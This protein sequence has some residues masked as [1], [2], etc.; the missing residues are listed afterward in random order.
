MA[1]INFFLTKKIH[2]FAPQMI[3]M[4]LF[5]SSLVHFFNS[6]HNF[7]N[8]LWWNHIYCLHLILCGSLHRCLL[9][10]LDM[11]DAELLIIQWQKKKKKKTLN[12]SE[13]WHLHS[14]TRNKGGHSRLPAGTHGRRRERNS[15]CLLRQSRTTVHVDQEWK[16]VMLQQWQTEKEV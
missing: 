6:T 16:S 4:W 8:T 1:C 13:R 5:F 9:H 11:C 15:H 12:Y 7:R 2:F 10:P 14:Q 3:I